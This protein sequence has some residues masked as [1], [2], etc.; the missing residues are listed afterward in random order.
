MILHDQ[1]SFYGWSNDN[2]IHIPLSI[3]QVLIFDS[4]EFPMQES[5]SV[6]SYSAFLNVSSYFVLSATEQV[7]TRSV[8][9]I[10]E[11]RVC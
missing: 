3:F 5:G 9:Y 10:G 11:S 6:Q 4:N 8:N 2:D 1:L 7:A